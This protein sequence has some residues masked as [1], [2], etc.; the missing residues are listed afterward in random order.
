MT[1]MSH[2]TPPSHNLL[3]DHGAGHTHAAGPA[4]ATTGR[5]IRWAWLY[6]AV[7]WLMSF[8]RARTMRLLTADLAAIQPGEAVLDVGCGT[9]DLTLE[10]KVRAGARGAVYGL[11]AAPE[12]IAVARRKAARR[13]L[14]VDFRV[15]LIE[16]TGLPAQSVDV[17]LSSLM[18]HHLPAD[19]KL[20]GLK[21]CRRVLKPGGRL[22][23]V[24]FA[25]SESAGHAEG[26]P[27]YLHPAPRAG[28]QQLVALLAEAGF[29][30]IASGDV[31]AWPLGYVRGRAEE[32]RSP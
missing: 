11:D 26:L 8:G 25:R 31:P 30:D 21:E 7:V 3:H 22:L 4:P 17:V 24:D 10:A 20:K 29:S 13:R 6:D 1:S 28:T 2:Q 9:G 23:I 27:A 19:V 5:L 18:M 15:G 16:A 14:D 12:M 32:Q